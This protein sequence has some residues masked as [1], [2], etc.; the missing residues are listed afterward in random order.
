MKKGATTAKAS[1]SAPPP[2]S[3]PHLQVVVH[4]RADLL[5]QLLEREA[6]SADAGHRWRLA[7]AVLVLVG[8]SNAG[9]FVFWLC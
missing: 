4:E 9:A 8:V 1:S 3:A 7:L 5:E 6:A 2:W